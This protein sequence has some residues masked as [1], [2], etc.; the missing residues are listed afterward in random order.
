M[1]AI[2]PDFVLVQL[3]R[4]DAVGCPG[5]LYMTTI[6]EYADNLKTIV[7]TV[8][9]FNGTPILISPAVPRLF[10]EKG[11]VLPALEDRSA[12]MRY[13][14]VGS[15]TQFIDLN[16]L[17]RDLF[18]ALG[19]TGSA[20]ISWSEKDPVHFSLEG[21]KVMAGLVVDALPN[22]LRLYVVKNADHSRAP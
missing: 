12:A 13:V 2:K 9:G 17:S 5:D 3:G 15:Q 4:V 19:E 16:Q 18:N 20:Y 22:I 10:D 1:L 8:R 7:Q 14:A 11:K 21:A 6:Q